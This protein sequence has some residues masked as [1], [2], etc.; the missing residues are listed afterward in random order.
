MLAA[1]IIVD[2]LVIR[3]G[4]PL[5]PKKE[6]ATRRFSHTALQNES[7]YSVGPVPHIS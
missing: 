7:L 5:S 2:K 1:V 3:Q 6:N 4:V